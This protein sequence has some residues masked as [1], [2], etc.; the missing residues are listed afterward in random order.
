M[1]SQPQIPEFRINPENLH[2]CDFVAFEQQRCRPAC[3]SA[4]FVC[5]F[6]FQSCYFKFY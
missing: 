2:P 4:V 5:L 6:D 3:I 1:E